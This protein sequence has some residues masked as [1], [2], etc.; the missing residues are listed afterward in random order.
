MTQHC[1][2]L[3]SLTTTQKKLALNHGQSRQNKTKQALYHCMFICHEARYALPLSYK[4]P[5]PPTCA[6]LRHRLFILLFLFGL[7][8]SLLLSLGLSLE[9]GLQLGVFGAHHEDP[10]LTDSL[11]ITLCSDGV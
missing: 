4:L 11:I 9:L 8:L 5:P 3:G 10:S 1:L 6:K 2:W 7:G